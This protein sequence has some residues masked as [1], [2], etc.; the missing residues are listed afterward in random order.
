MRRY[1][2]IVAID[3]TSCDKALFSLASSISP[4]VSGFKVGIPTL[5]SCGLGFLKELRS[6]ANGAFLIADLKLADIGDVMVKTTSLV[7]DYVDAVIA[8]AFVGREGA[9][10]AL[11]DSIR[12]WDLKL[13]LVAS[14]SHAGSLEF[15]DAD[16]DRVLGLVRELAPW[17]VV[18]PA[19]RP[20]VIKR[21]R[22]ELDGVKIVS[23]GVGAQG[24]R[25]G[26]A[27]CAGADY[28]IIGRAI[29]GSKDPLGA[30]VQAGEAASRC[31]AQ[32]L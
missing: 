21:V 13:I 26:D 8:H 3:E 25:P 12:K 27:I 16:L 19:T 23:P 28:E 17:G 15:Y 29:L 20:E 10:D 11:V 14:M 7:K 22:I 9:L 31:Q 24:A 6:A 32:R 1:P 2:L 5:I 18:A 4:I 30:A